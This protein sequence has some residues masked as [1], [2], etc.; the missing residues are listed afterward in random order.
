[1]SEILWCC[2]VRGPDDVIA[3]PNYDEAVKLADEINAMDLQIAM[4]CEP[5]ELLTRAVPAIWPWSAEAHAE[6]LL[7]AKAQAE[8]RRRVAECSGAARDVKG[9]VG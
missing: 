9:K 8:Y 6:N 7:D 5:F 4:K 2:H 1:M 3:A